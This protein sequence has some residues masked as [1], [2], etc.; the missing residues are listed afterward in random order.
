MKK[1]IIALLLLTGC[2]HH[3]VKHFPPRTFRN[4][5]IMADNTSYDNCFELWGKS[6]D[7]LMDTYI[8]HACGNDMEGYQELENDAIQLACPLEK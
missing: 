3:R 6:N 7:M 8:G 4:C 5:Y 2:H 1:L